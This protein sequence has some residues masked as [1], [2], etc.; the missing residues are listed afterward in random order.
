LELS[1]KSFVLSLVAVA[2][3]A[4]AAQ[5]AHAFGG[6]LFNRNRGRNVQHNRTVI[7]QQRIVAAP[8]HAQAVLAAPVYA[9]PAAVLAAPVYAA[10]A[11]SSGAL[12]AVPSNGG[13]S[14]FF[15]K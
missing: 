14:S 10:P 2:A 4:M 3:V 12:Q 15:V 5:P 11:C 8:V 7:V 13:C 9:A 6:G 1:M